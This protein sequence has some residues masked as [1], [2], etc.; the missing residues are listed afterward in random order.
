MTIKLNSSTPKNYKTPLKKLTNFFKDS[1]D[2]WRKRSKNKQIRIDDL[3]VKVRDLTKSRDNWK[4]KY[5]EIK[6]PSKKKQLN[7]RTTLV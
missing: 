2:K 1:R 6:I 5:K 7:L 4:Q 3:E